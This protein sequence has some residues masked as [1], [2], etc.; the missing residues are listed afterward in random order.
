MEQTVRFRRIKGKINT[1]PN[2]C[3]IQ[4]NEKILIQRLDKRKVVM[5]KF[6]DKLSYKRT[7]DFLKR[8]VF[9]HL[10]ADMDKYEIYMPMD[11]ILCVTHGSSWA[12]E[13][14]I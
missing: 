14:K 7:Y 5:L 13:M 10:D 9:M 3:V 2:K 8:F 11:Y 1:D 6:P 12:A 4:F